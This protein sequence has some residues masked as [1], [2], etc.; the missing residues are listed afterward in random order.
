M[1]SPQLQKNHPNWNPCRLV[2][3]GSPLKKNDV[4]KKEFAITVDK[5]DILLQD[6]LIREKTE[7]INKTGD[8]D[9]H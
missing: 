7:L 8:F 2:T 1:S 9:E 5:R 6:A 3:P 4:S